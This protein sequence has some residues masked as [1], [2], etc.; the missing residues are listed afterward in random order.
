[1][2][3]KS[4]NETKRANA[5]KKILRTRRQDTPPFHTLYYATLVA[6]GWSRHPER[7]RLLAVNVLFA[8][9]LGIG[10]LFLVDGAALHD[11]LWPGRTLQAVVVLRTQDTG[12]YYVGVTPD[13]SQPTAPV[14]FRVPET[15]YREVQVD[16][17]ISV[18]YAPIQGYAYRLTADG[19]TSSGAGISPVA[20]L[21]GS[22]WAVALVLAALIYGVYLLIASCHD[23]RGPRREIVG[24]VLSAR[25]LPP[26]FDAQ[27]HY[28]LVQLPPE[29]AAAK[30]MVFRVAAQ[31]HYA[32]CYPGRQIALSVS[33]RLNYVWEIR[34]VV[35]SLP[36]H[37]LRPPRRALATRFIPYDLAQQPPPGLN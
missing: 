31:F 6:L 17:P 25:H 29:Q 24:R 10:V 11:V 27:L 5:M 15:F 1:M 33:P 19:H 35:G 37:P 4:G 16:T 23:R 30:P 7:V 26:G 8:A 12:A 2:S 22:L 20:W 3:S 32:A 21:L 9:V 14:L 28:V 36:D 34:D 18:V 13:R